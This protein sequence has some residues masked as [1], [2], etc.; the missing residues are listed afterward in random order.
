MCIHAHILNTHGAQVLWAL[1]GSL[2]SAVAFSLHS[3]N[4]AEEIWM[5]DKEGLSGLMLGNRV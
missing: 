5:A 4:F 2:R 1:K 3:L